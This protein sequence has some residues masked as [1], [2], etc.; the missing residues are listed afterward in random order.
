MRYRNTETRS[1]RFG[2]VSLGAAC[3]VLAACGGGSSDNDNSGGGKDSPATMI[4]W[5]NDGIE[6]SNTEPWIS[7]GSQE[8]TELLKN[9][10]PGGTPS[11]TSSLDASESFVSVGENVFFAARDQAA[12]TELRKTDGTRDG[13]ER[14][15]DINLGG[16][17]SDPA[18]LTGLDGEIFFS[19]EDRSTGRELWKSD[20]T[21]GVGNGTTQ[22]ADINEIDGSNPQNLTVFNGELYFTA[23]DRFHGTE[24]WKTDGAGGVGNGTTQV[25]DIN[26][27]NEST[28]EVDLHKNLSSNPTSLTVFDGQLFFAASDGRSGTELW[29]TDGTGGVGN[30]T[31]QVADINESGS[32]YLRDFTVF[33]G[34]LFF[35]ANDGSTGR[36]LWKSDGTGG[37]GNG[38]TQVTDFNDSDGDFPGGLTV[39]EGEL[40]FSPDVESS[41]FE[42]W[43]TDGAG[44]VGNGTTQV[45]DI[46]KSEDSSSELFSPPRSFRVFDGNLFFTAY[47]GSGFEL[48][49]TDGTGGVGNGTT[50][51]TEAKGYSDGLGSRP[52]DLTVI[53][54]ELFFSAYEGVRDIELWKSD[55]TTSGTE[56]VKDIRTGDRGSS[57]SNITALP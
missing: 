45:A 47:G 41:S 15:A 7:D 30:G 38:T 9:I 37:V 1:V 6:N 10:G 26:K 43:K 24:L 17:D 57:P 54:D 51:V 22:V 8:G 36:E 40:F 33:K 27:I 31:T 39:F 23:E 25:A 12:G 29:K 28:Q 35:T 42:L 16:G 13:T 50:Q 49:K 48:W 5:A 46:K 32:S 11:K 3:L 18:H 2:L 34:Q 20:G 19:A 55:G 21:G 53:G 14:V 4:F 52:S 44:G 56:Q